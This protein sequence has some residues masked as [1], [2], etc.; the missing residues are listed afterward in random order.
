MMVNIT[1][2][3]NQF[4]QALDNS[5]GER[6]WFV[7]LHGSYSRGEATESSDIDLVVILDELSVADIQTYHAM[8]DTLPHRDIVCGFL[9]GKN[10]LLHWEPSDLFHFYYDTTPIKGSIDELLPLLDDEAVKRAIKTRVCEI[11]HVCIHN[12]LYDKSEKI[13]RKLYKIATFVI[14]T[15]C[16]TSTG[17][18]ISQQ[19]EILRLASP[20]DKIIINT[21]LNLRKGDAMDFDAMSKALFEWAKSRIEMCK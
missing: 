9:A 11:Y 2:F 4:T 12:M 5:F 7:G 8:L 13:L 17:K 10:E 21:F 14:Q 18:Y 19:R 15:I 20:D 1:E 6:V 16:F 3:M